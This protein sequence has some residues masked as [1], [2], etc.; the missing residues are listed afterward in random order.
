MIDKTPA[1]GYDGRR[2][3]VKKTAREKGAGLE[4]ND[5]ADP[6]EYFEA[7]NLLGDGDVQ[8]N[9]RRCQMARLYREIWE[10]AQVSALASADL[11]RIPGGFGPK[12]PADYRIECM[13]LRAYWKRNT[14]TDVWALLDRTFG[15]SLFTFLDD[16]KRPRLRLVAQIKYGLDIISL[17]QGQ[18]TADAL[19]ERWPHHSEN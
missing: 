17:C 9:N 18:I 1:P 19:I 5:L 3:V 14:P 13:G 12:T 4:R 11:G 10:G 7:R 8:D 6:V 2:K 16:R 15:A